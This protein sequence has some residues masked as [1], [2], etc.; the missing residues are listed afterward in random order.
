[1]FISEKEIH[2]LDK[3]Q[4]KYIVSNIVNIKHRLLVLIMLDCGL[5]VS[6]TI[7]LRLTNFDFRK[8]LLK[9][10]SL[11]KRD[12]KKVRIIP[13]SN[14]LYDCLADYLSQTKLE[15][16]S[17]LF[18]N[19]DGSHMS[20]FAVNKFLDRY[21]EKHNIDNLHPHAL[22]HTFATQHLANGT[23][24]ENIKE[25]LGHEKYDTTLIYAHIPEEILKS[26][27]AKV[28][29][30]GKTFIQKFKEFVIPNTQKLINI[31]TVPNSLLIGRDDVVEQINSFASRDINTIIMGGIGVGK[32]SILNNL[33]FKKKVMRLDDMSD[34]KK[35]LVWMLM[36]LFENDKDQIF[37]L[38]YSDLDTK[39]LQT[40]LNRESIANL[41][42]EICK[43]VDRNQYILLIDNV[44][45]I[46]PKGIKVLE[47]FKDHF[48]IIT[49]ARTVAISKS[50]F[51]W[52]FERIE[53]K[54]LERKYS[55]DLINKLSYDLDVEDY[56]LFRNHIYEQSNGNP[57]VIFELIDR[58]RKEPVITTSVIKDIRHFGSLREIDMTIM[59]VVL[60]ASMAIL[61]Y[62]SREIDQ[63]S[64]RFIGGIAFVGLVF[65]RYFFVY[66]KRKFV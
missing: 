13:L 33:Q 49:T 57:R 36:Y 51:L 61:R 56:E 18:P 66:T 32:T 11:K 9:V 24:L 25:L 63:D 22:R 12:N 55:L 4:S 43:L 28:E 23:P 3:K 46:S 35:S 59:I 31:S 54:P 16:D 1:M 47:M 15:K 21:S 64:L 37:N 40:K 26:N 34:I 30:Q 65:A 17:F 14:R 41:C 52:N 53:L 8:R 38:V 27:I 45:N 39:Q 50:S 62:L 10:E 19:K 7:T 42:H 44:D 58:Y 29:N 2:F 60:L 6:E 20:R 48:T 5:R